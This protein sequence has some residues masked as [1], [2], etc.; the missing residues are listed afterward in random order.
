MDQPI[1]QQRGEP[2][3]IA[4]APAPARARRTGLRGAR[5]PAPVVGGTRAWMITAML[6]VLMMINFADKAVLGL[7]ATSIRAEFGISAQQYGTISSAFFLLFSVAALVVGH[8][9]DRF[10]TSKVLLVLALIWSVSMLPVIGPAGFTVLLVSRIVLG[11]AEGPAFGVA[12][13]ALHKWFEDADRSIPTALLTIATSVGIIVGAPALS[14]MIVNHGWRSAF[15]LVAVIGLVWSALW[16]VIGREGPVDVHSV[17]ARPELTRPIDR[18]HV[19]LWQILTSRTWLGCALSS[20]AAYWSV[21]LL[22]AWL[23]AFL[24]DDLGY[25]KTE[26]GFIAT[27]PWIVAVITLLAQGLVV[28][29]L[30]HR[31][32]SSRWARGVLPGIILLTSGICTLAFVYLPH[33]GFTI[34]LV[35]LGL[36]LS[37]AVFAAATTVCGEIAPIGQ[38]GVVLGAFVAVYSLAG[39]I[40]PFVAG[41]LVGAAESATD[42]GYTAVFGITGL[43]VICGGVLAVTMIRPERDKARLTAAGA[44]TN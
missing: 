16:V 29:R 12:Q 20:F 38:R 25:S 1:T 4:P 14:W 39:V 2:T 23:P 5:L 8:L 30:M 32:V 31:G 40:A 10:S 44:A 21:S 3:A 17:A 37:G 11:A 22:I 15:V 28:Q 7:S 26:T 13:H 41:V 27:L 33:S 35:A 43:I 18:V 34:V 42:S 9:S 24:T 36:G 19:P 6:M